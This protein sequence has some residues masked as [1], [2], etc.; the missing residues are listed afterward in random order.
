SVSRSPVYA[1]FSETLQGVVT[2][3]AYGQENRFE[4]ENNSKTDTNHRSFFYLWVANRWLCLRT[5]LISATVVFVSG[6]GL[7]ASGISP[8]WAGLCLSYTLEF[9]EFLL[10]LVRSHAEMEMGMNAVE[11]IIEY[12]SVEQEP[13]AIIEPRPPQEWP[14]SGAIV[15]DGLTVKYAPDLGPVLTDLSFKVGGGQKVGIVGRTGAGKSTLSLAFFRILPFASGTIKIDGLDIQ[16]IGLH[17]LRSRLTIIPQDPVLFSGTLRQALDPLEEHDDE[18]I[19]GA[20]QRVQ[21]LESMQQHQDTQ[22]SEEFSDVESSSALTLEYNV[23]ENGT[24]FSQG[25]R[26]LLCLARALLRKSKVVILD[27]ATASV[28][29]ATDALIQQTIRSELSNATVLTIAHRLR[30]VVDYDL[31]LVLDHGKLLEFDTPWTLLQKE[32]GSFKKMAEET[33]E[34]DELVDIAKTKAK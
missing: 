7:V 20:L 4:T 15:V 30:T 3:R 2:I 5:D 1:L 9:T 16:N 6:A 11:R 26:Q 17:D 32:S 31:I 19:W 8:G 34:I 23:A 27:E 25:Q 28:D 14:T 18:A 29:N 24:N 33:G 22:K 10:W 21:F 13:A 12:S